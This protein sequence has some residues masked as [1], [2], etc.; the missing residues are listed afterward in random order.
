MGVSCV[1]SAAPENFDCGEPYVLNA[2]GCE[3]EP[4]DAIICYGP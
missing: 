1:E 4:M 3:D 2:S